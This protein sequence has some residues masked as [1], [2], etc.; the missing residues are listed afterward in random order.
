MKMHKNIRSRILKAGI[1]TMAV[2]TFTSAASAQESFDVKIVHSPSASIEESYAAMKKQAQKY[3]L[4]EARRVNYLGEH[5]KHRLEYV[6]NCVDEVLGNVMSKIQD[7][8]LMAYHKVQ[9]AKP[10]SVAANRS[11]ATN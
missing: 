8:S 2:V 5:R 1:A 3:C 7:D 9:N 6:Q 11:N 10:T 4:R